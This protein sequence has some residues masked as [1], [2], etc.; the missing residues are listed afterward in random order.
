MGKIARDGRI[1]KATPGITIKTNTV[2]EGWPEGYIVS[3]PDRLV[4]DKNYIVQLTTDCETDSD[5]HWSTIMLMQQSTSGFYVFIYG[6]NSQD[7]GGR[8]PDKDY[9]KRDWHFVI[10][11]L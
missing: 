7:N 3:L 5:P 8:G 1:L 11:D 6:D 2:D 10:Y 4:T 9:L